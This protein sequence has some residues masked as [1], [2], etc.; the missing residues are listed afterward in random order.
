[1]NVRNIVSGDLL[2]RA[3]REQ[4]LAK[5]LGEYNYL[6]AGSEIAGYTCKN[7]GDPVYLKEEDARQIAAHM[8]GALIIPF[9]L[10]E[11]VEFTPAEMKL[12][13]SN[14][15]GRSLEF[16]DKWNKAIAL[17]NEWLRADAHPVEVSPET[18]QETSTDVSSELLPGPITAPLHGDAVKF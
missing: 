12:N 9:E 3:R 10:F 2:R 14:L 15:H 5:G 16:R 4:M 8:T 6:G 7:I 13:T 11:Q 18:T 1:M 17:K